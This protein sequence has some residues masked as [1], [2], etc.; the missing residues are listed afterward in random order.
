VLPRAEVELFDLTDAFGRRDLPAVLA[1]AEARLEQASDMG[2]ELG[3]LVARLASH[4][5][6][7]REVQGLEA[8]GVRARDAATKLKAH[9]FFVGKLYEQASNYSPEELRH[10]LVELSRLDHALKGGS[11][12]PGDLSLARTLIATVARPEPAVRR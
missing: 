6:R 2:R 11:R 7:L 8:Q 3:G 5:R 10:A 1:I 4:V 12:A 9:P